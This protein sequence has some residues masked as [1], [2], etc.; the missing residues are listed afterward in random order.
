MTKILMDIRPGGG[1][2]FRKAF[3][4]LG[5]SLRLDLVDASDL[6]ASD[7]MKPL[8]DVPMRSIRSAFLHLVG[9]NDRSCLAQALFLLQR[10]DHRFVAMLPSA[11]L[12]DFCDAA[13]SVDAMDL[14]AETYALVVKAKTS[15]SCTS[16]LPA[17]YKH[18]LARDAML[19]DADLFLALLREML[20]NG[21]KI[22]VIALL[23]ALRLLPLTEFSVVQL[24]LRFSQGHRS[25]LVAVLAKV[26]LT[27][28]AFELFQHWTHWRYEADSDPSGSLS[29][30]TSLRKKGWAQVAD[31]LIERQVRLMHD[32]ASHVATSADCL[33]SLVK[34]LCR[35]SLTSASDGQSSNEASPMWTVPPSQLDK[36]RFVIDVFRHA[37]TPLDWTHY[38]LTALAQACFIAKDVPGAFDALARI[39][40]LREIPDKVD[41]TVLL[42]GLVELDAD[43]A[44]DLFIRH[45]TAPQTIGGAGDKRKLARSKK[46]V[47]P[48]DRSP[49]LAPMDPTPRL[50]SMLITRA[51][52]QKRT[53]LADKLYQFGQAAGIASR[54]GYTASLRSIFLPDMAP[55]KVVQTAHRALQQ[56]WEADPAILE[57]LAR[58][59][60]KASLRDAAPEGNGAVPATGEKGLSPKER[61]HCVQAAVALSGISARMKNVVN[62]RTVS[63]AL[64]AV[65]DAASLFNKKTS[66]STTTLTTVEAVGS[67]LR[68]A[69]QQGQ[70]QRRLQ[71]IACLDSI[72]HMLRWTKYFDTGDDY[73]NSLPLWKL[74]H[75]G[76]GQ[77]VSADLG[78]M[79]DRAFDGAREAQ[80]IRVTTS[81]AAAMSPISP[82]ALADESTFG[83]E[84]HADGIGAAPVNGVGP[85]PKQRA[86]NVLPADLFRR[87]IEAYLTLGDVSGAAEVASWMRDE[88]KVD[89]G[90][91]GEETTEFVDRIKA[92]VLKREAKQTSSEHSMVDQKAEDSSNILRMLA[93]QQ[94]TAH[95]KSWWLP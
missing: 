55:A 56:G 23:R 6:Q 13:R 44:V 68:A 51:L 31:P 70:E 60:L 65:I 87:I 84:E 78:E 39:S 61:L 25:Q 37:C 17:D 48:V 11:D 82:G 12:Q 83:A 4:N 43:K 20:A 27:E 21:Q 26:G 73:R 94:R 54:L 62:L 16:G 22:V 35:R 89:L 28:E 9:Q 59:L 71:W 81:A 47:A 95:T 74:S 80:Q 18:V 29:G 46:R 50:T 45:C 79:M 8:L 30:S 7:N 58:R 64:Y 38:Q 19:L 52:A 91:N 32:P 76:D 93:G 57:K 77:L 40:F 90:R 3:E 85:T 69:R 33:L 63:R 10:S 86:A 2:S 24:N 1:L 49:L 67:P 36:A 53:D 14:A 42:G 72:V 88:A 34:G 5:A 41:I 92:A 75:A 66:A 15:P